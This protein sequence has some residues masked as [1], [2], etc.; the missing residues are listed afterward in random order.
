MLF[1][2][3]LSLSLTHT[4][5]S[6]LLQHISFRQKV[7]ISLC[8]CLSLSHTYTQTRSRKLPLPL[9]ISKLLNPISSRQKVRIQ[10]IWP[11]C[12][13]AIFLVSHSL[14][15]TNTHPL[16]RS[17][18]LNSWSIY[19]PGRNLEFNSFDQCEC[20]IFLVSHSLSLSLSLS[21]IHT[22]TLSQTLE[23]YIFQA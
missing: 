14:S 17:I 5:S 12:E 2:L 9:Y 23:A 22:H 3:G 10:S 16:T 8:L 21:L 18:S 6:K 4:N 7:T 19:L 11:V 15:L 20:A 1:S 13:C